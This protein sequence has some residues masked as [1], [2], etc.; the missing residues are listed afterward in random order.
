MNVIAGGAL[1]NDTGTVI[2]AIGIF[3]VRTYAGFDGSIGGTACSL[4]V[5]FAGLTVEMVAFFAC[6]RNT[7]ALG[8]TSHG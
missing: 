7:H 3:D 1:G 4:A 2:I 5:F 6:N 8:R